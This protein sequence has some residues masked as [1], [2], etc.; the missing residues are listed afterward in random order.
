[1][2]RDSLAPYLSRT[3]KGAKAIG[4]RAIISITGAKAPSHKIH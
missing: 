4:L 1:L 2:P 3:R